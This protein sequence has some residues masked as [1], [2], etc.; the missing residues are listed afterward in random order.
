MNKLKKL[1]RKYTVNS[2]SRI[3]F[4]TLPVVDGLKKK[5]SKSDS[6]LLNEKANKLS[7]IYHRSKYLFISRLLCLFILY[8][9]F[10]YVFIENIFILGLL[11]ELI[12]VLYTVLGSFVLIIIV[13]ILHKLILL[14]IADAHLNAQYIISL[15]VKYNNK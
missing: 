4:N 6:L 10:V 5:V 15:D 2:V 9:S 3:Y 14:N 7:R 13:A 1:L 8:I 12:K 11:A